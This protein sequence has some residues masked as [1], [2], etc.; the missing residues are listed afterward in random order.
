MHDS[1]GNDEA[2][3]RRPWTRAQIALR[4]S[5]VALSLSDKAPRP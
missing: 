5:Q 1:S 3:A 2:V 4:T